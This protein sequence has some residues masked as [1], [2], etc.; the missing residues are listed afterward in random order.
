MNHT[1]ANGP[2]IVAQILR[3]RNLE[4][5]VKNLLDNGAEVTPVRARV[6]ELKSQLEL[7]DLALN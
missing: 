7:L 5:E 1:L 3:I 2:W 6:A 4:A